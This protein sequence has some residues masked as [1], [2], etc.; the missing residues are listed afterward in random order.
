PGACPLL[1]LVPAPYIR[2]APVRP[3]TPIAALAV[4]LALTVTACGAGSS[5]SSS[6][7]DGPIEIGMISSLTGQLQ[8]LGTEGRKA[9]E[10]AVEQINADGG[11]LGRKLELT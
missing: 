8:T 6:P 2:E 4:G 9:A 10:L 5:A 1:M 11:V 7:D 3:R